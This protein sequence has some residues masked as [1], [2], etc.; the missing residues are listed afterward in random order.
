MSTAP[1]LSVP[2][3]DQASALAADWLLRVAAPQVLDD[4]GLHGAARSLRRL[5][6]VTARRIRSPRSLRRHE[7]RARTA[8]LSAEMALSGIQRT[9]GPELDVTPVRLPDEVVIAATSIAGD[10]AYCGSYVTAH[11]NRAMLASLAILQ[12]TN[13]TEGRETV[14]AITDSYCALLVDL[15]RSDPRAHIKP[16]AGA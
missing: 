8:A 10:L 2:A 5:P 1:V 16:A 6:T 15:W 9:L 12:R 14:V 11:A 7:N 3:S 13:R 4:A